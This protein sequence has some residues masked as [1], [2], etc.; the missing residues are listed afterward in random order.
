MSVAISKNLLP[1]TSTDEQLEMFEKI[2]VNKLT[3]IHIETKCMTLQVIQTLAQKAK[4]SKYLAIL[5]SN[6]VIYL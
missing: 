2:I 6:E 5:I 4:K 1:E 3:G